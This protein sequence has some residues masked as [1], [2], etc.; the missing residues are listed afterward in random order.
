M[1]AEDDFLMLSGIQ[2]FTFCRRQW[3]LIHIEQQWAENLR[4]VDG[5]LFHSTAHD[6]GKIEKRGE[7]LIVRG[8]RVKS[9]FLGISG[10]CDVVEFHKSSNGI[11]LFSY[12]GLWEPYPVEYKK[13]GPKTDLSDE[14]Q[15]CAQAMCLE[16]MLVCEIP[17]GSL[18]YGENRRRTVVEFTPELRELVKTT[19]AEMHDLMS[20]G[21]T[22]KVKPHKGC[23][24]CSLKELCLPQ[25]S[26]KK[27][28]RTYIDESLS[29]NLVSKM[30]G[31]A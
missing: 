27:S 11:R 15:L 18:F 25:L 3:A 24:A 2:H 31:S 29:E 1:Y 28:V 10:N 23:S 17:K 4:T 9:V 20:R 7:L 12:E 5:Q 30:E 16:E 6:A 19:L 13:G 14:L 22:P 8:L 21:Y 26:R